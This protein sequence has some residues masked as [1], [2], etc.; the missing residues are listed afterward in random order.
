MNIPVPE[1]LILALINISNEIKALSV[2][3]KKDEP[4]EDYFNDVIELHVDA[5]PVTPADLFYDYIE[6]LGAHGRP[7]SVPA[8]KTLTRRFREYCESKGI[9]FRYAK[10]KTPGDPTGR[11]E[12]AIVLKTFRKEAM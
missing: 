1:N 10:R 3:S 9:I 11:Q 2:Q 12:T 4:L 6:W 7:S 5:F 8:K